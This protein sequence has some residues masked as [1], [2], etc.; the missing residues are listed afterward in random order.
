M[1][2]ILENLQTNA[3]ENGASL[4][5]CASLIAVPPRQARAARAFQRAFRHRPGARCLFLRGE[6]GNKWFFHDCSMRCAAVKFHE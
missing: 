5:C 1:N 6:G 2:K 3:L 4:T